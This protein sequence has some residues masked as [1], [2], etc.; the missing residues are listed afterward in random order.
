MSNTL[1]YYVYAYLRSKNSIHGKA[2]TPY[3]IGKGC[4]SRMYQSHGRVPVPKDRSL[5]VFLECN[6]SEI[7]AYAI[8]RRMILWYGRQIYKTGIL[9]NVADG[10]EGTAF[11]GEQNFFFNNPYW[12]GK[13]RPWTEEHRTHASDAQKQVYREGRG[14]YVRTPEQNATNS[15]LVKEAKARNRQL[16]TCI[17]CGLQSYSIGNIIRHHNDNCKSK[18]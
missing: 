14:G 7:G 13:N 4:G 9:L 16:H 17:H 6:L 3:Y 8:E 15:K 5:I 11:K 2:G 18:R 1:I 10:G 12:K